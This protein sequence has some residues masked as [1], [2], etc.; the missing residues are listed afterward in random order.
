MRVDLPL[1]G[2]RILV[3]DDDDDSRFY[4]TTVLESDG[5]SVTAVASATAVLEILPQLKPDAFICDIAMPDQDGYAL[6]RQIRGLKTDEGGKVPAVALTAYADTE[7][8][9][10]ALASG[11]QIHVA[12]PVA[13]NELVSIVANLVAFCQ[14]SKLIFSDLYA[15]GST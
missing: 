3:V 4:I 8:R 14:T 15:G 7:D 2:L 10:C 9:I 5:A 11:F 13:P 12:K 1:T 6:I